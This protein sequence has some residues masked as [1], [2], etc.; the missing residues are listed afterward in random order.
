M[1]TKTLLMVGAA[2]AALAYF[3]LLRKKS[4]SA[5][6]PVD[7][8]VDTQDAIE[9]AVAPV[10]PDNEVTLNNLMQGGSGQGLDTRNVPLRAPNRLSLYQQT[11]VNRVYTIV[12]Q[13]HGKKANTGLYPD[14][15]RLAL[16]QRVWQQLLN[17]G[18]QDPMKASLG[19]INVAVGKVGEIGFAFPH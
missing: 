11:F 5:P 16:Y 7:V 18:V 4:V 19:Q 3:F 6:A 17:Q 15:K 13:R 8:P 1:K 2:G 9:P 14:S 10:K 12:R